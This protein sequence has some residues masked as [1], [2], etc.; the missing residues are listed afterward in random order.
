MAEDGVRG[1]VTLVVRVAAVGRGEGSVG[2][3]AEAGLQSRGR[4]M[5]SS[6]RL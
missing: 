6:F 5:L 2:V 4:C 1:R 3:V